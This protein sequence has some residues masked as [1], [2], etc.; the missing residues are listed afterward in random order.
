MAIITVSRGSMSGGVEFAECL[1][2]R[3]HYRCLSREVLV[4]AA[5]KIGVPEEMLLA[6]FE[7]SA[8]LWERLTANRRLYLVAVQA[9]LADACVPGDLV[10]HGHAGHL[11]LKG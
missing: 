1:A 7:K 9:A 3:L 2:Q 5:E 11:L 8:N 6:K 4:Q 10:Y